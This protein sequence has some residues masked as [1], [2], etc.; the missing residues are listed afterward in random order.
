MNANEVIL[1]FAIGPDHQLDRL[2]ACTNWGARGGADSARSG[3]MEPE[4]LRGRLP[5]SSSS[6]HA[7]HCAQL[8]ECLLY[9]PARRFR[10]RS[11]ERRP[12]RGCRR[13]CTRE[14]SRLAGSCV[15]HRVHAGCCG[16]VSGRARPL[17]SLYTRDPRVLCA[18]G[19]SLLWIAAAFQIFDG[20]QT[21]CTGALRGLGETRVPMFANLVGYWVLGLPLGFILCFGTQVGH[22]WHVDWPHA[23]THHHLLDPSVAL[24]K[25]SVRFAL[26]H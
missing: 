25:D 14:T 8:R 9:G 4:H 22:L 17:I 3:S 19:P 21:V 23:G 15:E 11:R 7:R 12:C 24:A 1:S 6:C 10:G 18:V 16:S 20:I 26:R 2:R 13:S 5:H